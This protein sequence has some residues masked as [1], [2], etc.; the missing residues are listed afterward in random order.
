MVTTIN[1]MTK[2][3]VE[4]ARDFVKNKYHGCPNCGATGVEIHSP[5]GLPL[6]V[7]ESP[8][9]YTIDKTGV[10]AVPIVCENCGYISIFAAKNV[11]DLE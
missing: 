2:K 9:L 8:D 5:I 6:L 4:K 1:L 3:N 10:A 11:I 7:P